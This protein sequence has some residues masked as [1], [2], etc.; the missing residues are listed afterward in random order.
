[1]KID[2]FRC[3]CPLMLGAGEDVKILDGFRNVHKRASLCSGIDRPGAYVISPEIRVSIDDDG[4][5]LLDAT[6]GLIFRL[7]RTGA[8]IWEQLSACRPLE[9]IVEH[10]WLHYG[11]PD[12]TAR[13]DIL[14]F[15]RELLGQAI[16]LEKRHEA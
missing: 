9:A 8:T 12:Q 7:N 4:A 3:S 1:L 14:H 13:E 11:V 16:L 15:I 2:L 5:V 6:R 10:F